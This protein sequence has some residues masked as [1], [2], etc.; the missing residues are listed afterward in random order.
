MC[1]SCAAGAGI[2]LDRTGREEVV[3][4]AGHA[5]GSLAN[6]SALLVSFSILYVYRLRWCCQSSPVPVKHTGPWGDEWCSHLCRCTLLSR[7]E[8]HS[9]AF[10]HQRAG[11]LLLACGS[12]SDCKA[13]N[14]LRKCFFIQN[15]VLPCPIYI[16]ETVLAGLRFW[17]FLAMSPVFIILMW[18]NLTYIY[19]LSL[20]TCF[21]QDKLVMS[22]NTCLYL[23]V[24]PGKYDIQDFLSWKYKC[25]VV[26]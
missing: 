12:F 19:S 3:L 20:L 21:N 11:F 26:K 1:L 16:S 2:L 22:M 23:L 14:W 25:W 18:Q 17:F 24:Q 9:L 15:F 13:R 4:L 7:K 8:S 6:L 5:G 10:P